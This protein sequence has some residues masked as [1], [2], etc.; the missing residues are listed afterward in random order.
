M[1]TLT[2]GDRLKA[3]RVSLGYSQEEIGRQGFVSTP[4]WI[5]LE[6]GQRSPSEDLLAKLVVWLIKG[7]YVKKGEGDALHD[8]LLTLK[9]LGSSQPFVRRLADNF[10][11]S[12]VWGQAL[13][14][15]P[16]PVKR[17]RGRPKAS[18]AHRKV[19]YTDLKSRQAASVR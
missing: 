16:A 2:I 10:A 11:R 19:T 5:K 12:T 4:G 7:K 15:A 17:L 18:D 8:E 3:L 6:N 14:A 9:Y 1:K 13:P